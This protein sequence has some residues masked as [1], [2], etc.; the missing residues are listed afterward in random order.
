[1]VE[2]NETDVFKRMDFIFNPQWIAVVGASEDC[3]NP[4]YFA[5]YAP[6]I[7]YKKPFTNLHLSYIITILEIVLP[8]EYGTFL[9]EMVWEKTI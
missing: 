1:M 9:K 7:F 2:N 8:A 3:F 4:W 5:P 6:Y